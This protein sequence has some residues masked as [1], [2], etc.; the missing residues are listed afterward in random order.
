MQQALVARAL[1]L[2]FAAALALS[3]AA[4]AETIHAGTPSGRNF[5][6]LPLRIGI[7]KGFFAKEGLDLEVTDFGGGAKLQQAFVAGGID[8]AVSAGT[9]MAFIAKGAPE[10]AVAVA[11]RGATL[12]ILVPFDSPARSAEDLKH[13]HIGV[14][15]AGSFTEWLMRR[16]MRQHGWAP[17]DATLVPIGSD[18]ANETALLTTH[19]IDAVVAPAALGYQL[20][21]AKRG[22]LVLSHFELGHEFVGQALYASNRII[23]DDPKA[24]R[25]FVKAWLETIAWM[26]GHK[27]ETVAITRNYTHYAPEVENREYDDVIKIFSPDG[28]FH[29]EGLKALGEAFVEMKLLDHAP[30]MTKLYT[31][32]FLP[33]K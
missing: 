12:G 24:V 10:H 11:G 9:D 27:D 2:G 4:A 33:A 21:L 5:T 6:F 1:A 31:D 15:T 29:V 20:E 18:V 16:Y 14:T 32:A 28:R 3:G 19:R 22:R 7:E 26:R 8:L 25:G 17:D 23:H 30:E 13:K